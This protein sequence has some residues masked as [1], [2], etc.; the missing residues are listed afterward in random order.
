[1]KNVRTGALLALSAVALVGAGCTSPPTPGPDTKPP[2]LTLPDA[3]TVPNA[4]ADGTVVSYDVYGIDNVDGPVPT[5]C[6]PASGS[7]FV[8]G[9]TTVEC[10][11]VD[12]A[13]NVAS[14]SFPLTVTA[15]LFDD[16]NDNVFDLSKWALAGPP[17]QN[18]RIEVNSGGAVAT[19]CRMG[20]DFD[21]SIEF[22]IL[23]GW[24]APTRGVIL[25]LMLEGGAGGVQRSKYDTSASG[26]Y[27]NHFPPSSPTSKIATTDHQ[28]ALRM[29]RTGSTYQ[30]YYRGPD[31]QWMPLGTVLNRPTTPV[32]LVLDVWVNTGY[33][34][35]LPFKVAFDN[36]VVYSVGNLQCP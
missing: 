13:G 8:V 36:F 5:T 24:E 26:W 25:G 34:N 30:T 10:S 14:G 19:K 3:I 11:A 32:A 22:T 7:S 18:G 9:T 33:Y 21:A 4:G 12:A 27:L 35:G 28:G 29:K 6:T 15:P 31:G 20:G 17:E 2:A 23:D 1:M 16:F